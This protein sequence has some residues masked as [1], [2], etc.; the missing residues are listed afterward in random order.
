[1]AATLSPVSGLVTVVPIPPGS[2]LAFL[3]LEVKVFQNIHPV[4]IDLTGNLSRFPHFSSDTVLIGVSRVLCGRP[5]SPLPA[6][7]Q[8]IVF[9]EALHND[10]DHFNLTTGV[11]TCTIPGV[12][13][14][15]F[16]IELFQHAVKLG[17]M[18]NDTQILEKE[19]K[20]KDNYRHLSGNVV[21]QLTL[22][23]RVWLESKLDTT[24]TEKGPIQSMFFGYLLYGN[25]P[26]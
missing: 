21:L 6:P 13:R 25:Y 10:Q 9:K 7:S 26:G 11:F 23:D 20:A 2:P 18:K 12:Y 19:S 17:L 5:P 1:M 22:G 4:S 24:E 3:H 16:D 15:G 14:F 8:P